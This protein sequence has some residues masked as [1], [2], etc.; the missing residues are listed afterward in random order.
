[1]RYISIILSILLA[2][3][4]F[5]QTKYL[6]NNIN[7]ED[8]YA[9][10]DTNSKQIGL[11]PYGTEISII[12]TTSENK[13]VKVQAY[14]IYLLLKSDEKYP[15][16]GYIKTSHIDTITSQKLE[17]K[18]IK[19]NE[20][21]RLQNHNKVDSIIQPEIKDIEQVKRLFDNR[22]K[23]IKYGDHYCINSLTT[24][25]GIELR[26]NPINYSELSFVS[27]FPNQKILYFIG[28]HDM[29]I[30]ISTKTGKITGIPYYIMN[31]EH[32]NFRLNGFYNGQGCVEY[33]IQKSDNNLWIDYVFF[34]AKYQ[35]CTI[36]SFIWIS[37][38]EFIYRD[39]QNL[40]DYYYGKLK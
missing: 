3:S 8:L 18:T 4:L 9:S 28:G 22:I 26:I 39:Q 1:M 7:G 11:L 31:S 27:Y 32:N 38:N 36:D 19:K 24:Y 25:T 13:W 17:I 16:E 37:D 40:N 33:N 29:D 5:G 2:N 6:V 10:A 34:P 15:S 12:N 23:W 35:S 14:S 21:V 20:F 30:G